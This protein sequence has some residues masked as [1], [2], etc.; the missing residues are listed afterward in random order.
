[1]SS[2][3]RSAIVGTVLGHRRT[4]AR[5]G[6][7]PENRC[8]AKQSPRTP[9]KSILAFLRGMVKWV[10]GSRGRRRLGPGRRNG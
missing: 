6:S 2:I 1:M 9:L 10:R 5:V 8:S 4:K 7:R 3:W